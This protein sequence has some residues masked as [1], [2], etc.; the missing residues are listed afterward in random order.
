M[1]ARIC[2]WWLALLKCGD[3]ACTPASQPC[4]SQSQD[5]C[6]GPALPDALSVPAEAL[7]LA[8]C[9]LGRPCRQ[10]Q[11]PCGRAGE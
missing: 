5:T 10:L 9:L 8:C 3:L 6:S 2:R 7:T 1:V 4:H 11:P